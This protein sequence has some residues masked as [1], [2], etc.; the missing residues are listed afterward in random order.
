[1]R[2]Q[3][4]QQRLPGPFDASQVALPTCH[5]GPGGLSPSG[6]LLGML[7]EGKPCGPATSGPGPGPSLVRELPL[8]EGVP[9]PTNNRC[10]GCVRSTEQDASASGVTGALAER[11]CASLGNPPTARG[12][13]PGWVSRTPAGPLRLPDPSLC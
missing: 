7:V 13:A 5:T 10:L 3:E 11:T 6:V 2:P 8:Q 12:E 9:G 4:G 1:M